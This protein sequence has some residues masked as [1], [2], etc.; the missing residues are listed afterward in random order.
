MP[1]IPIV[2][3]KIL[4]TG[5]NGFIGSHLIKRLIEL[6]FESIVSMDMDMTHNPLLYPLRDSFAFFGIDI[7]EYKSVQKIFENYSGFDYVFHLAANIDVSLS[8]QNPFVD[9]NSNALASLN[10]FELCRIYSVKKIILASSAM[11]YGD[12]GGLMVDESYPSKPA[13][14]YAATKLYSE[15][16]AYVYSSQYSLAFTLFRLFNVYGPYQKKQVVFD[17]LRKLNADNKK[18]EMFGTGKQIRDFCFI[19]D[20]V[21]YLCDALTNEKTVNN[22]YN[23]GSGHSITI[24][25]LVKKICQI[26]SLNP[27]IHFTGIS[28]AGDLNFMRCDNSKLVTDFGYKP[29]FELCDGLSKMVEW[30]DANF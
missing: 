10:T 22:V 26:K 30:Y 24:E 28:W 12:C 14:N 2:K 29:A 8:S 16:L 4:V 9:F 27:I 13:S 15:S 20:V 17:T 5:G 11:I 25:E 6:G 23:M 21:S 1:Q 7:L 18:L 19:N 3:S